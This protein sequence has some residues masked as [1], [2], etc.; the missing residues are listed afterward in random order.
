MGYILLLFI[1]LISYGSLYPFQF[2]GDL[3]PSADFFNWLTDNSYRTTKA[4]IVANILLFVPYGFVTILTISNS[5]RQILHGSLL[6]LAGTLLAFLLQYLQF[7]IPAR[8]PTATDAWL[9][10]LGITVGMLLA[11]LLKQYSQN[12][13]PDEQTTPVDWSQ[14]T[15]PLVLALLWVA[16]RLFPFVPLISVKS[17]MAAIAPLMRQPELSF[18]IIIRDSIGWLVFFYLLTR[19][20]FDRLSQFRVL[21]FVFYILSLEILIKGNQITVNDLLAALCA[22]AFFSSLPAEQ[23]QKGLTRGLVLAIILTMIAPLSLPDPTNDYLWLPFSGLMKG[24]PWANGE[25]LLLKIYLYATFIYMLRKTLVSW[26][27]AAIITVGLLIVVSVLQIYIGNTHGEFTDP[28]LAG[29]IAWAISQLEK[30]AT[31]E[32]AQVLK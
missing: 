15:I 3:L 32:R 16:W 7:Y 1:I 9:N 24:N 6:L 29:L 12:H 10:G 8:V 27:G 30:V 4:D 19:P 31:E 2:S 25:L 14:I 11:H 23:L 13:L 5:R 18:S 17:I 22:F 20:P 26:T 21:K 28:L